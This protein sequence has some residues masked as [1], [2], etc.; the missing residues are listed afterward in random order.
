MAEIITTGRFAPGS[1]VRWLNNLS[2]NL[3]GKK[4]S[5]RAIEKHS[6]WKWPWL[7]IEIILEMIFLKY[8]YLKILVDPLGIKKL[9]LKKR[10]HLY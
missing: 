3:R 1:L 6:L 5:K 7:W 9:Q 8:S 2:F 10:G 4:E